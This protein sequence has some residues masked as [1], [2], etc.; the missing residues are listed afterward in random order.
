MTLEVFNHL[1]AHKE[2]AYFIAEIG[3]TICANTIC[4]RCPLSLEVR[5]DHDGITSGCACALLCTENMSDSD[6]EIART[7]A[8]IMQLF[9]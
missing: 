3:E 9:N 4:T 8:Q 1:K 6:K 5:L 2:T 7:V